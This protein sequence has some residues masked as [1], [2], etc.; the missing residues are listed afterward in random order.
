MSL[1]GKNSIKISTSSVTHGFQAS[2]SPPLSFTPQKSNNNKNVEMKEIVLNEC[3]DSENVF[4]KQD[5]NQ[6]RKINF[7]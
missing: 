2:Y 7:Y 4:K 3:C 1:G 6:N 5:C